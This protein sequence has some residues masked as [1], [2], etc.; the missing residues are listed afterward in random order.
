MKLFLLACTAS[1]AAA[2]KT[3]QF[4]QN[5]TTIPPHYPYSSVEDFFTNEPLSKF[6]DMDILG[7]TKCAANQPEQKVH[8]IT[9]GK[10]DRCFVTVTP[11]NPQKTPM[12]VVY[13]AHGSGG[14]AANCGFNK[15]LLG[16]SWTDIANEHGFA[17]VCGEAVQYSAMNNATQAQLSGGLWEIPEVFT[18]TTGPKCDDKDSFDN[19]YMANLIA[20]LNKQP[21]LYDTSR[22]FVTG[23]SMGSAFT[24]WQGPC[25]HA[26]HNISAMSTHSTGLKIKGDGL[27]FPPDS[28]NTQ[29]EWGECPECKYWPTVIQK[30]EG[31][32]A[33]VFDN[34]ADPN[35]DHPF[36]YQSS[37][38]LVTYWAKAGNRPAETHYGSGGHCLQHS[39]EAIA[40]CMDDGT[41]RLIPGGSSPSPS[42]SVS[43]SPGGTCTDTAPDTKETCAQQA[44]DGKC[45][46][47]WMKGFC[48]KTCFQCEAG[49]GN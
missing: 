13:F 26:S 47:N 14:S 33:C 1:S 40:E 25:L 20:E 5:A 22:L 44:A 30:N 15:D 4:D 3:V 36:F 32:K 42:P 45:K 7:M 37:E 35:Q 10:Q 46:M 9:D 49:C 12:P 6:E 19:T 23:C 17:F 43:P 18:D 28:Y 2:I 8:S 24:V 38:Q 21:D 48:C 41:G 39:F 27:K 16:K 31:L 29:Y 34:T 11:T